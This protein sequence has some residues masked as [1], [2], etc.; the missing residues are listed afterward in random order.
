MD[1]KR[2]RKICWILLVIWGLLDVGLLALGQ[3]TTLF[4]PSEL[5]VVAV[6]TLVLL[7]VALKL[8]GG[9]SRTCPKCHGRMWLHKGES[10]EADSEEQ[11][12][13]TGKYVYECE[14]CHQ[15]MLPEEF[16]SS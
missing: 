13:D 6:G 15:R 4:T 10:Q 3:F 12:P 1:E 9:G 2:T 5:M 16:P 14:Q 7:G 11:V 8:A